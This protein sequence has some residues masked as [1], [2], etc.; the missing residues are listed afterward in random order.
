MGWEK[1]NGHD[2]YH[3]QGWLL[4]MPVR[5]NRLKRRALLIGL[6]LALV[7]VFLGNAAKFYQIGFIQ[8]MDNILYDYRLQLTMPGGVDNRIVI[9][10]IDEKSL[11]EEGRWPWSRDRLALLMDSLF[12]HYHIAVAGLDVVFAEKDESSGLKVLQGL[13]HNQL[14]DVP[15]FQSTLAQIRPQLDYDNLFADKLRNRNVVLGYYVTNSAKGAEKSTSGALPDAVFAPGTFN[16]RPV[17][18]IQFDGYG[19]NLPELQKEAASAGHFNPLVD[20][21]G[22]VRRVPM[23]VE[24]NGAYYESL[25]LAIVRT[26]L[27]TTKLT[28]GYATDKSSNY[29]GLEWL[30]LGSAQGNFKIPLDQD[31]STL[32][33]YRGKRGSF[34]Y[35]SVAD[36][37]HGRIPPDDLKG[38]IV[39]IGTSAPGLMDLRS[40]PVDAVYPGVE[41]HA[42]MIAGILDQNLKQKPPYMIGAEVVMLFVA[43]VALSLLLP[44]LTP[45][46]ASLL[47]VSVL[48]GAVAGNMAIWQY[49]N[50]ALPLASGVLMIFGLFVLDILYGYFVE[51]RTK[52]QITH[53]FGKYV[54]SE[55]VDEMSKNPELLPSMDGESRE[56][57]ILFS[58]VRGFTTISEKLNDPKK[59]SQLMN[60]FLTPL[61]KVIYDHNGKVDKYMGDCIM[62]FWGAPLPEPD[63]ARKAMLAGLEMQKKL[64]EL[65]PDFKARFGLEIH[66][67][68]G[69]NTG[70]VSVGNMGS[71]ARLAYTVMGDAVNLASRLE[72]ITKQYGVGVMVGENTREAV[73]DFE[74]RELDLVKVKGK[75]EPVAIYEPI[76]P[77]GEASKEILEE[78]KMFHQALKMYRKQDWDQ[79]EL[80]LYNLQR[81]FPDCK[82]YD[83]YA[84][85]VAYFRNN[86]PGADWDG[87]FVFQTK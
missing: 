41:I 38:K 83:V 26:L 33:S 58:D 46:K 32:V 19:G 48:A 13:A 69:I 18:F 51:A 8:Q 9:L 65:Q 85:R 39:L 47:T 59:L 49:W 40:T 84:E 70:K 12:D 27:G 20:S 44:L 80:Q 3:D 68:V 73:P 53:L 67:G 30:D 72:G 77:K 5:G 7:L 62:A 24:Y 86:P 35:I 54:P 2:E 50:L 57:T 75:D 81:M 56:M 78:L 64:S 6:G 15:Q 31:V 71:D 34:R 87:V 43:G 76:G 4:A 79:A 17:N 16:G 29:A 60:A 21:D 52:R 55:L 63:H 11:R 66:V 22:V 36:A 25:S 61:S 45:A 23:I 1:E 37:L 74:Y 82:L 42:N 10:D 14:K 28:P